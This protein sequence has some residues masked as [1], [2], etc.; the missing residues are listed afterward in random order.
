M[1]PDQCAY[2]WTIRMPVSVADT[3]VHRDMVIADSRDRGSWR[4]ARV[5]AYPSILF[6]PKTTRHVLLRSMLST[7]A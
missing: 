5:L 3:A 7:T 2:D 6:S 1:Q 4:A